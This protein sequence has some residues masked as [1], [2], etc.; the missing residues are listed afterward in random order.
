MPK[1]LH[2]SNKIINLNVSDS[3]IH[4]RFEHIVQDCPDAVA[5]FYKDMN[6]T[7]SV[8]NQ[9]ANNLAHYLMNLGIN[10]ESLVAISLPKNLHFII[11]LL[12]ILKSGGAYV[13][14]PPDYPKKLINEI[15]NDTGVKVLL[16]TTNFKDNFKDCKKNVILLDE[17]KLE[18]EYDDVKNECYQNP[19]ILV[20]EN[21]LTCILYT[22]GTT[23]KPKGVMLHHHG[24]VSRLF[25]MWNNCDFKREDVFFLQAPITV[26]DAVWDIFGALLAGNR[27]VLC[28]EKT[29]NNIENLI[30]YWNKNQ[31]SRITLVVSF[32]NQ[33]LIYGLNKQK[34][35]KYLKI[36]YWQITGE[37]V[38]NNVVK[39]LISLFNNKIVVSDCYGTTEAPSSIYTE[40]LQIDDIVKQKQIPINTKFYILNEKMEALPIGIVGEIYIE[41]ERL[42]RGYLN[43]PGLTASCFLPNPYNSQGKRLYRTGDLGKYLSDG[44]IKF[45]GR[46]DSQV[47]I[48]G[49]RIELE[50]IENILNSVEGVRQAIVVAHEHQHLHKRLVGYIIPVNEIT[51]E[52]LIGKCRVAC[53]ISLP[54]HIQ[55]SQIIL[56][57]KFPLLPNGKV[58]RLKLLAEIP[59]ER[60]SIGVYAEPKGSLEIQLSRIWSALLGVKKV[61]REDNFFD[62]GG[63]SL[64]AMQLI[65][66]IQDFKNIE[67]PL[68]FIFENPKL[69]DLGFYIKSNFH[70]IRYLPSIKPAPKR[71]SVPLSF[72]Q[73]RLWFIEK[74]SPSQALYNISSCIKVTGNLD[75]QALRFALNEIIF[76]HESLRTEFVVI[77]GVPYQKILEKSVSFPL[78]EES[79]ELVYGQKQKEKINEILS[80][81]SRKPFNFDIAPLARGLL[82]RLSKNKY[83]ILLTFHH[84]IF[85]GISID[86]LYK[87]LNIFYQNYIG[88]KSIKLL[89][90]S[91]QYADFCMWQR[92]HFYKKLI[93]LQLSYWKKEL[94]NL[95]VLELPTDRI[96]PKLNNYQMGLYKCKL[97]SNF[98]NCLK[99]LSKKKSV[100]LFTILLAAFHGTLS[101]YTNQHDI[102]TG[103][104]IAN[105]RASELETVIGPF[106]NILV[107]RTNCSNNPTFDCL[108][109]QVQRKLLSIYDH[110]DVP[111]EEL[112]K[113]L[114]IPRDLSRNPIFQ[115][116]FIFQKL[117][118]F[119]LEDLK[120]SFITIETRTSEVD[121]IINV[122]ELNDELYLCFEYATELFNK[123]RITELAKFYKN[124]II[125]VIENPDIKLSEITMIPAKENYNN[126]ISNDV[127]TSLFKFFD[128][129]ERKYPDSIAVVYKSQQI[130]FCCLK[131]RI[132]NLVFC[133]KKLRV[134]PEVS[135]GIYLPRGI[136]LIV[137]LLSVLKSGGYY[138][139]LD[140]EHYPKQRIKS[141]LKDTNT[142][143]II[144]TTNLRCQFDS[145]LIEIYL[146]TEKYFYGAKN[147]NSP[148]TI[149][150]KSL[151]YIIYTSGTTGNLKGV[152]I[153]HSALQNF[154]LSIKKIINLNQSD[155]FLAITTIN[156]DIAYLE[157]YLPIIS[158]AKL[159]ISD[160]NI[161]LND[162]KLLIFLKK[163]FI[164]II[165]VV[166]SSLRMLSSDDL[167]KL[168][169]SIKKLLC[170]GELLTP[171]LSEI[172]SK[173][174]LEFFNLYGPTETT[175]W[176]S[177][178]AKNNNH[179]SIT[180]IGYPIDNTS[181]YIIDK[182]INQLPV[183]VTGEL[184]IAGEGL[185]R[186]YFEQ[187]DKTAESF[188]ANP[189]NKKADRLY[190][191][192]DLAK[193]LPDG[194]IEFLGR[195]DR[196]VKIRGYR[197]ELR[198]IEHALIQYKCIKEAVV[199][200]DIDE[201]NSTKLIA[202]LVLSDKETIDISRLRIFLKQI[203]V[204]PMIPSNYIILKSLPLLANG[205]INYKKLKNKQVKPSYLF[206]KGIKKTS[207][208]TL[209]E[210][211]IFEIWK[212]L[213]KVKHISSEDNFFDIGGHSLMMMQVCDLIEK[214][215][216]QKVSIVELFDYPT[217]KS[218]SQ[219]LSNK[220]KREPKF[221]TIIER[222]LKQKAVLNSKKLFNNV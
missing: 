60:A 46:L 148:I 31:V 15:L 65:S 219:Y 104:P 153:L 29:S 188:V 117:E 203:L 146:D 70:L 172:I 102:I 74:L 63:N 80:L 132:N 37:L 5:L 68:K 208:K 221:N 57:D 85:D 6:L 139:P 204:E 109:Q 168:L 120:S 20:S 107:L 32:L 43:N 99:K 125:S 183:G 142:K 49:I 147:I 66:R 24:I 86:I 22:S 8:L 67:I 41:G 2:Q 189:F 158:G 91:I 149:L 62:L 127:G 94:N 84:I 39:E 100:S 211:A 11:G 51:T 58:N 217:I 209:H 78:L 45:L 174:N 97:Q 90:L 135:V 95:P 44:S 131:E 69:K 89:P 210:K 48:N 4:K 144:T 23:G 181:V 173:F 113:K 73:Q 1:I 161:F 201:I 76:R 64:S 55:I 186:G 92:S 195:V 140:P 121:I 101:R 88:K 159:V 77:K 98:T 118:Q 154:L 160:K 202:Y 198:E 81:Y 103:F 218:L 128:D 110:Q 9:K 216:N 10:V 108:L 27:L 72:S 177:L 14:I 52:D 124:F 38:V 164:N 138:I 157:L 111:F 25:W 47:K 18:K 166:P 170:G 112:V 212:S 185:A 192:G 156:F 206:P 199:I 12:G 26:V 106:A 83:I 137:G 150:P 36:R 152:Q 220:N 165:Q 191:T 136:E 56:L 197:I 190:K 34:L 155:V 178:K 19:S 79:L 71:D 207:Y 180:N 134:G 215:L 30:K 50:N 13:P 213:L 196:Q 176:S 145:S 3:C 21:N 53:K 163:Y 82:I 175:I 105:R 75:V 115:I 200:V 222:T 54:N 169:N 40:F 130:T 126:I 129:V 96:R 35:L 87:E 184:C 133:L 171:D 93:N 187:A 182:Y 16:T 116:I 7:Y 194:T 114:S 119:N 141:I 17:L 123:E 167:E 42:A 214:K 143:L 179:F 151:A 205:K 162:E 59:E 61:G 193:Y 33:L 122:K 28:A